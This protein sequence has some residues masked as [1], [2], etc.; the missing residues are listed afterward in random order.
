MS[1][2]PLVPV[3]SSILSSYDSK[4]G[5]GGPRANLKPLSQLG[6][7]GIA[8]A[9]MAVALKA[10]SHAVH[11]A[12]G[13]FRVTEC[14]RDVSVQMAARAK[15]DA[16][17]A[18]GK[19]KPG[20]AAFNSKTMKADY[21]ATPGKSAHNAGRAIDVHIGV[22]NFPNTPANQQLDKLWAICKPLGWSPIIKEANEGASEAWHFD[23]WGELSGVFTRM[24]YEQAALCGALLVGHAGPFQSFASVVQ[25]LLCRAGCVIGEIDGAIGPRTLAA[26]AQV[27][28]TADAEV[29]RRVSVQDA[30]LL[31]Q[32]AELPA[33]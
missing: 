24:G 1:V 20:T 14:H 26:A 29:A 2:F 28:H 8:T 11:A 4:G 27:L 18:A 3:D 22:L 5:T 21:V 19:P 32:L 31:H 30:T 10:L 9:D 6:K 33:R 12:G 17:V 25:A 23:F 7:A 13:D 16:W 15:Y